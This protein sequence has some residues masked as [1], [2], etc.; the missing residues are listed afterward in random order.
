[1]RDQKEPF[2]KWYYRQ[3]KPLKKIQL[4]WNRCLLEFYLF[5]MMIKNKIK[6]GLSYNE[7]NLEDNEELP[8]DGYLKNFKSDH[9]DFYLHLV[10]KKRD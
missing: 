3:Q 1:M 7:K 10:D 8:S 5:R 9:P 4:L 2:Y 6:Y